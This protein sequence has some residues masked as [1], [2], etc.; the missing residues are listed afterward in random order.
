[1]CRR[2]TLISRPLM[3]LCLVLI[4]LPSAAE[5]PPPSPCEPLAHSAIDVTLDTRN[6]EVEGGQRYRIEDQVRVIFT[7]MNPFAF[8][9]RIGVDEAPVAEPALAAFFSRSGLGA[10]GEDDSQ[11]EEPADATGGEASADVLTQMARVPG[12]AAG[13]ADSPAL[14]VAEMRAMILEEIEGK[15]LP[16]HADELNSAWIDLEAK[17]ETLEEERAKLNRKV[18]KLRAGLAATDLACE[19]LVTRLRTLLDA[20]DTGELARQ[21]EALVAEAQRYRDRIG[22]QRESIRQFQEEML[23]AGA[24]PAILDDELKE[25]RKNLGTHAGNSRRTDAKLAAIKGGLAPFAEAKN[26]LEAVSKE[27]G[28]FFTTRLVGAYLEPT[29][30]EVTLSKKKKDD[31][32]FPADPFAQFL[33]NFGGRQRFALAVGVTY[34]SLDQTTFQAIQGFERGRG[35]ELVMG[36]DGQP[37]LTRVIGIDEDSSERVTPM[38]ALH[39][40]VAPG[41]WVFDAVHLTLGLNGNFSDGADLESLVGL[42]LSFAEERFFL[43]VGAYNGRVETIEGD[44]FVGAGLPME[45]TDVPVHSGREWDFGFALSYKIR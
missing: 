30:A 6:G 31:E 35:G 12:A 5:D 41:F 42:S 45:V 17:V 20:L 33:L 8:D 1:M 9:Y 3:V 25:I 43:T 13:L 44:F 38:F 37:T 15:K 34:S 10:L 7:N 19:A 16:D 23:A 4:P 22:V 39:T 18:E 26:A 27:P 21:Q 14:S 28:A 2:S 11:E 40:R 36:D 29:N 24:D 32:K